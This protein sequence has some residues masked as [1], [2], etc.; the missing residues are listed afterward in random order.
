MRPLA[1]LRVLDLSTGWQKGVGRFL[2]ELGAEVRTDA[3]IDGADLVVDDGCADPEALLVAH[4]GLVVVTL[5]DFGRTGPYAGWTGSEAALAALGGVLSRSGLPGRPPVLPP[6]GLVHGTACVNATWAALVALTKARRTGEG[7]LVDVSALEAVVHGFDPG[8]GTQG[9]AAAGRAES[10]P[11]GRPDARA[12]YP[13]FDC[14]DGQVRIC[15]LAPRQ[16]RQMF[17]WLGEPEEFADPQYDTIPGRFAAADRLHPHIAALFAERTREELA[18]EGAARGIPVAG[19]LRADEVGGVA[20]FAATGAL[21][22]G[23]PTGYLT[24]D[25][26]RATA[27]AGTTGDWGV[28]EKAPPF[29]VADPSVVPA[30][31]LSGLRVLDLGVIVFGAELGRLL[32]D[33]GAEVIKVESTAFPDGLRQSRRGSGVSVSFAWGQRN[34]LSLGLDLRTPEGTDVL[35][36]LV[37]QSDV[38]LSNFKPGTLASLGFG[39]LAA[40]NPLVVTSESSAFG[41]SGPWS[42][43]MGYGPLV[44][45]STGVTDLWRDGDAAEPCDGSTVYPDHV[46]AQVAAVGVLATLLGR[47]REGRGA[48][49][50]TAQSDVALVHLLE[51]EPDGI[52]DVH[53]CAGDDDWL[54]V[55]LR[56]GDD[57]R[58]ADL[59]EASGDL[60]KS[61][62][63]WAAGQPVLDAMRALQERGVAAGA[64]LRLPEVLDDPQLVARASFAELRHPDLPAP[65][66]ASARAA[67]FSS[68]PDVEQRPAPELG[69][70]TREVLTRLLGLSDNDV[71][72]LIATGAVHAP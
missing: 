48:V 31:L 17:A 68:I 46:A 14:A 54:A 19:V 42:A 32:A 70:D 67:V 47:A 60:G 57:E 5:T 12:F 23:R 7:E 16:W 22:D 64:L 61:V 71:D 24:L 13:V 39:D 8:F 38:V 2:A 27:T 26:E 63:R 4:P 37:Q 72:A 34:K 66:P 59:L 11:R 30:R 65:V 52:S 35:R 28:R 18:E 10:F 58:L 51:A 1:D 15:L 50:G 25:G 3:P 21:R 33:Q 36:S 69:R 62:G 9:S 56:E 53:A 40:L 6:A 44:R 55:T 49:V 29:L 41:A 43:R 20:H 45:A